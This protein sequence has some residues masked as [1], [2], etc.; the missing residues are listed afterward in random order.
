MCASFQGESITSRHPSPNRCPYYTQPSPCAKFF[1]EGPLPPHM[2]APLGGQ[3][4]TM[5]SICPVCS[6]SQR[7]HSIQTPKYH[8]LAKPLVHTPSRHPSPISWARPY[9]AQP[10]PCGQLF[11][12]RP[13]TAGTDT[14]LCRQGSTLQRHCPVHNF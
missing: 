12:E 14:L 9:Y 11:T 4:L 6:S 13:L 7:A 3:T 2:Q 5:Y 8:L 1:M 10:P